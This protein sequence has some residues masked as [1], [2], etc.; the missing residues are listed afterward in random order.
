MLTTQFEL[1]TDIMQNNDSMK[2]NERYHENRKDRHFLIGQFQ[3]AIL[4]AIDIAQKTK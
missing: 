1:L 4:E 3:D 2:D